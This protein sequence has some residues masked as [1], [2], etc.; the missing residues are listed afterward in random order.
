MLESIAVF[1]VL[2][3]A[4]IVFSALPLLPGPPFAVVAV[5][6]IPVVPLATGPVDDITWWVSGILV[7]LGVVITVI[8]IAAP[9]LAKLF[10]GTIGQS[11]RPAALG[12][13]VGLFAGIVLSIASGCFGIAIPVLVALPLPLILV[14]PFIGALVGESTVT[15]PSGESP[16]ERNSR[17]LRSAFVQWLGLLTTIV[18]KVGYCLMVIPIGIWLIV[19]NTT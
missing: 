10:E 5:L 12:S 16:R 9:W 13:I 6:L 14:T 17:I 7:A 19:R 18:L 11:S 8:D 1:A 15:G 3:L 2:A 4:G